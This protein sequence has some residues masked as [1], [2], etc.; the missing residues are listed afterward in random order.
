MVNGAFTTGYYLVDGVK[1]YYDANTNTWY[2][3]DAFGKRTVFALDTWQVAT[4]QKPTVSPGDTVEMTY[5]FGY[6]GP[7]GNVSVY[8]AVGIKQTIAGIDSMNEV[9]VQN[10]L[11]VPVL[12]NVTNTPVQYPNNKARFVI[13]ADSRYYNL[14]WCVYYK[15]GSLLSPVY[16]GAFYVLGNA[17]Y[18]NLTITGVVKV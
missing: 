13:P 5:G 9:V 2:H 12:A 18:S 17:T 3:V 15:I 16:T 6:I 4:W 14:D 11:I 8:A 1:S 7:A 10:P